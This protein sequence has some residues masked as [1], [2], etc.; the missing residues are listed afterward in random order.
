MTT[1][2]L[3]TGAGAG[4]GRLLTCD[5][6][7]NLLAGMTG[8]A[9][10]REDEPELL[11]QA[12]DLQP[13]PSETPRHMMLGAPTLLASAALLLLICWTGV[14]CTAGTP[15][16]MPVS[17]SWA[18]AGWHGG[19]HNVSMA[20]E[21]CWLHASCTS[22]DWLVKGRCLSPHETWNGA[23]QPL[24]ASHACDAYGQICIAKCRPGMVDGLQDGQSCMT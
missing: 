2:I 9:L 11:L 12:A 19:L 15:S 24:P 3:V 5:Q 8:A 1:I 6:Q 18:A 20:V 23:A 7:T 16:L 10:L 14:L 22:A 17:R 13:G 21:V 4:A